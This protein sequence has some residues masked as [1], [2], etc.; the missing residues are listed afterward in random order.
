MVTTPLRRVSNLRSRSSRNVQLTWIEVNPVHRASELTE[1]ALEL[2][3]WASPDH[4]KALGQFHERNGPCAQ[5][6]CAGRYQSH[7]RGTS[8]QFH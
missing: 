7:P 5:A 6:R 1:R 3:S 8:I 4:G 2:I